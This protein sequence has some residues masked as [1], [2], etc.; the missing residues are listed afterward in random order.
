MEGDEG[1]AFEGRGEMM[2]LERNH[3]LGFLGQQIQELLI[4]EALKEEG[5]RLYSATGSWI[6][7]G[8]WHGLVPGPELS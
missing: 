7:E 6:S 3:T 8:K 1:W 4:T 5:L 2:S